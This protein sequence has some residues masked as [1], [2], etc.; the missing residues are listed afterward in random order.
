MKRMSGRCLW[1]AAVIG[2][3]VAL[4][5]LPS[6]A[7]ESVEWTGKGDLDNTFGDPD[8]F[9]RWESVDGRPTYVHRLPEPGWR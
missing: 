7:L 5:A 9:G 3:F 2:W 6:L 4:C 8:N 1:T